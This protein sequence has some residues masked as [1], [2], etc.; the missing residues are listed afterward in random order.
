M[1]VI[2]AAGGWNQPNAAVHSGAVL[3]S[4]LAHSGGPE[5]VLLGASVPASFVDSLRRAD[6]DRHFVMLSN[7]STTSQGSQTEE[8]KASMDQAREVLSREEA[9]YVVVSDAPANSN[10]ESSLRALLR[11]DARFKLL[12]T[13]PVGSNGSDSQISRLY[14]YE[15]VGTS[16]AAV[17]YAP[18]R[19]VTVPATADQLK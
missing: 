4:R 12:G 3:A 13:F 17:H 7:S 14:L 1:S 19:M 10:L 2:H 6:S 16:S 8:L 15:N 5:T 18:V 11:S 9:K